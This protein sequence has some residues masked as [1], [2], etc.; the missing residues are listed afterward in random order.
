MGVNPIE[1]LREAELCLTNEERYRLWQKRKALL[2]ITVHD[3]RLLAEGIDDPV[4]DTSEDRNRHLRAAW[5]KLIDTG[6]IETLPDWFGRYAASL[7][8]R[9]VCNERED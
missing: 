9:G 6:T 2:N 7:I 4:G 8:Q 3:A 1:I 5:Q